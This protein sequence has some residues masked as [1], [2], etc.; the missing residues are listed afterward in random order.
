[1]FFLCKVFSDEYEWG[2]GRMLTNEALLLSQDDDSK[3]LA[4]RFEPTTQRTRSENVTTVLPSR[5]IGFLGFNC[6][7]LMNDVN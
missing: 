1:M 4:Y 2:G 5:P 7:Y 6:T 3:T